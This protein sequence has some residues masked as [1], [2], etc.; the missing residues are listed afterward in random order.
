MA[1]T[2]SASRAFETL[3]N[4]K[5]RRLWIDGFAGSEIERV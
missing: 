1:F 2:C 4:E 5:Q 3:A